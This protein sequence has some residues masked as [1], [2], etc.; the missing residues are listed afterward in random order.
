MAKKIVGIALCSKCGSSNSGFVFDDEDEDFLCWGCLDCG[1]CGPEAHVDDIDEA[2]TLWNQDKTF[3]H[4][5]E[6]DEGETS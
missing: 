3:I 5:F 2:I 6:I 4:N 1:H